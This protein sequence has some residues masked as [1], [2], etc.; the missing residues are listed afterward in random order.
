VLAVFYD[1]G[2][3]LVPLL[4]GLFCGGRVLFWIGYRHGAVGR[5]FGFAL[6]FYPSV[7]ALLLSAYLL[8]RQP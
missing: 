2:A 5:A 4:G 6:T 1:R 8:L 7:G 3:A